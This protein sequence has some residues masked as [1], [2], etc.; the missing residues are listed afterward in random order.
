MIAIDRNSRM[1]RLNYYIQTHWNLLD[2]LAILLFYI[3]FTL[4]LYPSTYLAGVAFLAV[5]VFVWYIKLFQFYRMSS[6]L[7]PYIVMM[8]RMVRWLVFISNSKC[9]EKS[10]QI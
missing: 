7:G 2:V 4:R 5:D 3:G 9:M 8:W 6:V 1:K 10:Y